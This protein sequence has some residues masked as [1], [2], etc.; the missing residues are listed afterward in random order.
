[1]L[2]FFTFNIRHL[3]S[4]VATALLGI[5]TVT[6]IGAHRLLCCECKKAIHENEAIESNKANN[7]CLHGSCFILNRSHALTLEHTSLPRRYYYI[8]NNSDMRKMKCGNQNQRCTRHRH[9]TTAK[10]PNFCM[11]RLAKRRLFHGPKFG[12]FQ[13]LAAHTIELHDLYLLLACGM[14]M[15]ACRGLWS[16]ILSVPIFRQKQY[17][18]SHQISCCTESLH[19]YQVVFFSGYSGAFQSTWPSCNIWLYSLYLLCKIIHNWTVGIWKS[20]WIIQV[21]TVQFK[22]K[23]WKFTPPILPCPFYL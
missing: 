5:T 21:G 8:F 7:K 9:T 15:E 16:A 11:W 1:M 17:L 18:D 23:T 12:C 10:W 13:K 22:S 19:V 6:N 20:N 14:M 2:V 3:I 4:N